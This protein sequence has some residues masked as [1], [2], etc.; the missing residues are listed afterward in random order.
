MAPADRAQFYRE[1]PTCNCGFSTASQPDML[2]CSSILVDGC[3]P[4]DIADVTT[5]Q[6]MQGGES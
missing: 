2:R 3:G 1:L 5:S 6:S 4:T